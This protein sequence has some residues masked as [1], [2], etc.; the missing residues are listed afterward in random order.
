M[1]EKFKPFLSPV[2]LDNRFSS[3]SPTPPPDKHHPM[4]LPRGIVGR[5]LSYID[6]NDISTPQ[7]L[8]IN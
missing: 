4:G 8:S 2:V 5:L 1:V 7:R 3:S 6:V